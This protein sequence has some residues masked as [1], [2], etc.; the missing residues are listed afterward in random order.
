MPQSPLSIYRSAAAYPTPRPTFVFD[1]DSTVL[2]SDSTL[3][4][5]SRDQLADSL[6][7]AGLGGLRPQTTAA[8]AT[9]VPGA[10]GSLCRRGAGPAGTVA[11]HPFGS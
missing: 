11:P 1:S 5:R 2:T 8:R 7:A 3:R 6:T 4:F 10:G 9:L